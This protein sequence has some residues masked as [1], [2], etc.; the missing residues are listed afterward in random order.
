MIAVVCEEAVD[1]VFSSSGDFLL[2]PLNGPG[3]MLRKLDVLDPLVL[4]L[5]DLK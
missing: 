3:D 2:P 5:S 1:D 4:L